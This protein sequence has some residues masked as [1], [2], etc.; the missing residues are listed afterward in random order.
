TSFSAGAIVIPMDD[1]YNPDYTANSAPMASTAGCVASAGQTCYAGTTSSGNVRLP[2]GLIYLL[3]ENNIPVNVILNSTKDSLDSTD[4]SVTPPSGATTETATLLARSG[5]SYAVSAGVLTEGTKTMY[6]WGMPFVVDGPYAAQALAVI[7]AFSNSNS[8]YFDSV[9]IHVINYSFQAPVAAVL[10]SRP[11]PVLIDGSALETFFSESGITSVVPNNSSYMLLNGSGSSY[12]YNWPSAA[13]G[14]NPACPSGLCS[15]LT[16]TDSDGVTSRIVDVLWAQSSPINTWSKMPSYYQQGGTTMALG[17]ADSWDSESGGGL[18]G[19]IYAPGGGAIKGSFC[20]TMG[21]SGSN[22]TATPGPTTNYPASNLYLQLGNLSLS[23][24]GGGGGNSNFEF[25]SNPTSSVA[26]LTQG[27]TYV[28]MAGHPVVSGTQQPGELVY[29]SSINSWHGAAGNKDG[30]LHIMYNSLIADGNG[31]SA[32]MVSTE[33]SRSSP[34]SQRTGQT[35][36]G[37]FDWKIPKY[38]SMGGNS[39]Y[40]PDKTVYPYTT[41]HF[42]QYV[43]PAGTATLACDPTVAGAPCTWDAAT[44]IKAWTSRNIFVGQVSATDATMVSATSS[45]SS[46]ASDATI[47]YLASHI[48]TKLGGIDYSTAAVIEGKGDLS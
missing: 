24:Q 13:L 8:G 7:A 16:W 26:A 5:T 37:T 12:T 35:Y 36:L 29:F 10:G 21:V 48:G 47:Q 41:G 43:E 31:V 23:V 30:G 17:I 44:H 9:P 25:A 20:A 28:A 2:F 1:C 42:R 22:P 33:L 46:L 4:F 39:L 19:G 40:Q 27:S 32:P 3:A 45:T 6:Y 18:G 38:P 34:V 11:K 15:G 14:S